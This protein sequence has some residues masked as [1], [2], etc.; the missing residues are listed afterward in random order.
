MSPIG[1]AFV[2]MCGALYLYGMQAKLGRWLILGALIFAASLSRF[3]NEWVTNPPPFSGPIDTLV[4][5]GRPLTFLLLLLSL[6]M[7]ANK[8]RGGRIP[9]AMVGLVCCH[10]V[11]G[12]KTFMQG[13]IDFGLLVITIEF[14][15]LGLFWRISS[16]WLTNETAIE[17]AILAI[18][19]AAFLFVVVNL[20]QFSITSSPQFVANGQSN[21][22]TGNPQHAAAL[23]GC[24]IP[25]S[26][27]VL[28]GYAQKSFR[29][30]ALVTLVLVMY[31]LSLTGSRT[32]LMLAALSVLLI[33]RRQGGLAILVTSGLAVLGSVFFLT[34]DF[35]LE[36]FLDFQDTR[37]EVWAAMWRQFL[38]NPILGSQLVTDR[39]GFGENS[40][41]AMGA[42]T[43]LVGLIRLAYLGFSRSRCL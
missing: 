4:G 1:M 40:W 18:F 35:A 5:A 19:F 21:G 6:T 11:I 27:Y 38:S 3:V 13:S 23:M 25:A 22:T 26:L 10:L 29:L 39:L 34:N 17:Y 24:A 7:V 41:L 9:A 14:L 12:L 32:G 33:A 28:L 15:I 31:F 36:K 37:S 30:L 16:S 42:A 8:S 2:A 20:V 43:G